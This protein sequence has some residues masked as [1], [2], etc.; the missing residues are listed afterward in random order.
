[1]RDGLTEEPSLVLQF[2]EKYEDYYEKVF[3]NYAKEREDY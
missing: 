1:M 2:I 3:S